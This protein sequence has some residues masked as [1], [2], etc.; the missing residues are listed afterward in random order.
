M[1]TRNDIKSLF[2][3]LSSNDLWM[4]CALLTR[5]PLPYPEFSQETSRPAAAA[6]W[7]YPLV[8][9][10]IG[11]VTALSLMLGLWLDLPPGAAAALAL[12]LS[13][14]A[15][16]AMHEDGLADCADGF[17]GGWD[18]ERRLSI[19]KDS[20]IGTYGVIALCLSLLLRWLCLSAMAQA[21]GLW[22]GLICAAMISRSAMVAIM[23]RLPNARAQGLS[24]ATGTPS[25]AIAVLALGLGGLS[26][27]FAPHSSALMLL[28]VAGIVT[29]AAGWTAKR[30]IGGQTGDVLGATQQVVETAVLLT[31]T[32]GI[33]S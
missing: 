31:L 7:A 4:A 6:A 21:D 8:G 11:T 17:W 2:G 1:T 25:R 26:A 14:V 28:V 5:L 29:F 9:L 22:M 27:F 32:A 12:L 23:Q 15:T 20:Q 3:Q 16:G 30:K 33:T 24:H 18:V 10:I 19:M 13:I